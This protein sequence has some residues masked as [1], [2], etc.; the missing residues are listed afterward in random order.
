[1]PPVR[2][3]IFFGGNAFYTAAKE[4]PKQIN[5]TGLE[6]EKG[7]YFRMPY[8]TPSGSQK[9]QMRWVSLGF[10]FD[11]ASMEQAESCVTFQGFG[12][13]PSTQPTGQ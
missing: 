6:N 9:P 1:M 11:V 5:P 8:F 4:I 13:I 2:G 12:G 10:L 7:H 3:L